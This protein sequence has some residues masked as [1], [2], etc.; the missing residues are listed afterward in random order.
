[1]KTETL[2]C[3]GCSKL[4]DN[5]YDKMGWLFI[6]QPFKNQDNNKPNLEHDF[7]FCSFVCLMTWASNA[8]KIGR[9]LSE[10][11]AHGPTP[12]GTLIDEKLPGVYV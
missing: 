3:D 9:E 12:R 4:V 5:D 7:H 2:K 8:E 1:M 11:A 10:S 6:Y